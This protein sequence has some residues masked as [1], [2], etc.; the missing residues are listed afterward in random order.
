FGGCWCRDGMV[1]VVA[2]GAVVVA[3]GSS[4]ADV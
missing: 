4:A 2:R 3:F 1:V